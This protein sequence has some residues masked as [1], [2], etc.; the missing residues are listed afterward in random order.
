MRGQKPIANVG[1]SKVKPIDN[2]L[3]LISSILARAGILG[4]KKTLLHID[5]KYIGVRTNPIA[6]RNT[7]VALNIEV[8]FS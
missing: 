2:S 4:P 3:G 1:I 7:V 6:A 8:K 5:S